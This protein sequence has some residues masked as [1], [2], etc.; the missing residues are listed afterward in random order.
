MYIIYIYIY[1]HII[2]VYIYIYMYICVYIYIYIYVCMCVYIYIYIYIHD[3]LIRQHS[4]APDGAEREAQAIRT[5]A[6]RAAAEISDNNGY[7]SPI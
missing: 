3:T 1:I 7:S 4:R 5:P 2:C 6:R